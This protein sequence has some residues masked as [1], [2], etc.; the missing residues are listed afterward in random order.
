[1]ELICIALQII[2]IGWSKEGIGS[3]QFES[4]EYITRGSGY[5][6]TSLLKLSWWQ[7]I[8]WHCNQWLFEIDNYSEEFLKNMKMLN[9]SCYFLLRKYHLRH[10]EQQLRQNCNRCFS[11]ILFFCKPLSL[12]LEPVLWS[13]ILIGFLIEKSCRSPIRAPLAPGNVI[14][15][16]GFRGLR[17]YRLLQDKNSQPASVPRRSPLAILLTFGSIT[18]VPCV[19]VRAC[20]APGHAALFSFKC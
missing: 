2:F 13:K 20:V 14:M 4:Y 1:M 12:S 17:D 15:F 7:F 10:K 9:G 19:C 6:H 11:Y 16:G 3:K 5:S 18:E 8:F